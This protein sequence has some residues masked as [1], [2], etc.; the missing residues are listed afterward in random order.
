MTAIVPRDGVPPEDDFNVWE[1][2]ERNLPRSE[3]AS[4]PSDDTAAEPKTPPSRRLK[5][6][7]LLRLGDT[8][9]LAFWSYAIIKL[10]VA[11]IDET[12]LD[13]TFPSATWLLGYRLLGLMVIIAAVALFLWRWDTAFVIAYVI[14][15]PLIVILWKIP[16]FIV[17]RRSWMFAMV[18]VNSLSIFLRDFRYNIVSKGFAL[19][20]AFFVLATSADYFLIPAAF[21]LAALL[22]LSTYR[23]IYR[24]FESNWFLAVQK[25]AIDVI[26]S[27]SV[28]RT[29]TKLDRK[30]LIQAQGGSLTTV[31]VNDV[32]SKIQMGVLVNRAVYFWAYKLDQYR[33]SRLGLLFNVSAYAWQF[34]GAAIVFTFLNIAVLKVDSSQFTFSQYPSELAMAVYTVSP[35]GGVSPA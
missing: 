11:D 16:A 28:L 17:R 8:L 12:V 15:F 26:V 32:L 35:G 24:T 4:P 22:F 20:A 27:S 33:Q 13:A 18:A 19:V 23:V 1:L 31:E 9:G 30:K 10:F 21:Y 2:L 3:S 5:L 29:F 34:M 14:F 25:R 7:L 6:S